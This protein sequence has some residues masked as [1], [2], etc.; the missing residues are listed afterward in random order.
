MKIFAQNLP[1]FC[2]RPLAGSFSHFCSERIHRDTDPRLLFYANFVKFGRSEIGKV[3]RY[4]PD[5]KK[6]NFASLSRSR[7]CADR[8]KNL[9]GPAANNVLRVPQIS[10]KS[11]HFRRSYSRT[12]EQ[13]SNARESESNT[14]KY[15]SVAQLLYP[16]Y[17]IQPVVK[18]VE[19][20]AASCKRALRLLAYWYSQQPPSPSHRCRQSYLL[21]SKSVISM[22]RC[23]AVSHYSCCQSQFQRP[24]ATAENVSQYATTY[25]FIRPPITKQNAYLAATALYI[26]D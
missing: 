13:S 8:A 5:K 18:P 10:A 11:V 1:F 6:Q 12:R 3:V 15:I 9:P 21:K 23:H 19:Q 22:S 26:V 16:V 20:P 24:A 17:T 4:L 25:V 2:K 14:R 7:F